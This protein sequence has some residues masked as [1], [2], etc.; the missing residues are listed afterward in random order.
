VG[1]KILGGEEVL[2]EGIW[3]SEERMFWGRGVNFEGE[4]RD[5]LQLVALWPVF[6]QRKQR[7]SLMHL[8]CSVGVSFERVPVSTSMASGS[9]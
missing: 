1:D 9:Q 5:E 3:V 7:P 8:A 4:F 2:V 6:L